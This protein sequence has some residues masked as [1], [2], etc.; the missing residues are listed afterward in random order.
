LIKPFEEKGLLEAVRDALAKCAK[1]R[2]SFALR[3]RAEHLLGTLTPRERQVLDLVI[4]G[5]LNKEVAAELGLA[6]ITVK[7]HRSC[8]LRKLDAHSVAELVRLVTCAESRG[9]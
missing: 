7:V 1:S 9:A 5:K 8:L 2:R 4:K 6:E 3:K